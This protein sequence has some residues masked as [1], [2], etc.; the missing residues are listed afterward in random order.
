MFWHVLGY[1]SGHYVVGN[2]VLLSLFHKRDCLPIL[3]LVNIGI[4]HVICIGTYL[5]YTAWK[6]ANIFVCFFETRITLSLEE[7]RD[8]WSKSDLDLAPA[9]GAV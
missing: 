7:F 2:L 5:D 1:E 9:S 4:L 8:I 6:L 3:I